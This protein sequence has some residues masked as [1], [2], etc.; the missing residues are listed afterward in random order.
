MQQA[1]NKYIASIPDNRYE[2][3]MSLHNLIVQLY[4]EAAIDMSYKMPTYRVGDG[5][6]ALANQKNYISLYTCGV[7]HLEP[8]KQ[9]H[10]QQKTGKGC[11]NFRDRDEIHLDDLTT[12]ITHAFESP[13]PR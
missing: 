2:R 9:K 8:Y 6:V 13:K 12:V 3:F 10:P 4:P 1:I 7:S 5:W 11:I